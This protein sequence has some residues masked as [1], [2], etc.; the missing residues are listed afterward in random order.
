MILKRTANFGVTGFKRR[1][2]VL[3]KLMAYFLILAQDAIFVVAYGLKI[4]AMIFHRSFLE[5]K[6]ISLQQPQTGWQFDALIGNVK[7]LKVQWK[8]V[9]SEPKLIFFCILTFSTFKAKYCCPALEELDNTIK[10]PDIALQKSIENLVVTIT[11]AKE[12]KYRRRFKERIIRYLKSLKNELLVDF[13]NKAKDC[14]AEFSDSKRYIEVKW[15]V[16]G[17]LISARNNI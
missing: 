14:S 15:G 12:L 5:V 3:R 13:W 8:I 4:K 6:K 10:R 2:L 16:K 1:I 7:L 17:D 11:N 9:V